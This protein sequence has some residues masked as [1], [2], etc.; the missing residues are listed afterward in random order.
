M[1]TLKRN[2]VRRKFALPERKK[3]VIGTSIILLFVA[4]FILARLN[5]L[6]S[7]IS[8]RSETWTTPIPK[9]KKVFNLLVMGYGGPGHDGAY[10][11]DTMMFASVDTARK[12]V[13]LVSI[14]R[15]IWV[16]LPTRSG[17]EFASKINS[18][19]QTGLFQQ[20]YP[21]IP[22]KYAGE[23][24]ASE[25]VRT[26]VG[27]IVGQPVE[28]YMAIDFDGFR[29]VV[30]TLGGVEVNVK[31][32]FTD[33]LYPID[34]K[35]D[36][37]CGLPE[38]D[39]EAFEEKEK[40]ATESPELAYPCRYQALQ[41]Q[42][43]K[44]TMDGETALKFVRSRHSPQDGGDFNR[45]H[46]QQLF[47]EALRSRV[48][49]IGFIPKILPL[50]RDLENN[51]RTDMTIELMQRFLS[52]APHVKDYKITQ[53]V[54]TTDN[55]LKNDISSDGQYILTSKNGDFTWTRLHRDVRLYLD[56]K[57]PLTPTPPPSELTN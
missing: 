27:D 49:S 45:A 28:N 29:Q 13:T 51:V 2:A 11:T 44:Q 32:S 52:E 42:A 24:G 4:V 47:L 25:L 12:H 43:G 7:N 17:E 50:M 19:Y 16:R 1:A 21:D 6:Y 35:E 30:D 23:Q 8:T 56:G 9:E 26:V 36:D 38:G 22:K 48:L 53:I 14:P 3:L 31:R 20:N 55:Y 40:I 57:T 15:D 54:L 37:L 39:L 33:P 41:F 5:S 18:V 34:G 46:R 10:L